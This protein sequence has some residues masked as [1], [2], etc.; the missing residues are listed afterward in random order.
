MLKYPAAQVTWVPKFLECPIGVIAQVPKSLSNLSFRVTR[1]ALSA[2]V[3]ECSPKA[4]CAP[5][6]PSAIRVLWLCMPKCMIR[7]D[8]NKS[9]SI[10]TFLYIWKM[11]KMVAKIFKN[12]TLKQNQ[13]NYLKR[14]FFKIFYFF[15]CMNTFII[16]SRLILMILT[17][18]MNKKLTLKFQLNK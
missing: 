7:C 18:P 2:W 17:L 3:L 12:L 5:D 4:Y 15:F 11:T 10:K 16:I 13:G 6:C 9:L 14:F 8:C 1:S